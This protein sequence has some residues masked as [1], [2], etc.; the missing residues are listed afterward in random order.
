MI[1]LCGIVSEGPLARVREQLEQLNAPYLVFNQRQFATMAMEFEITQGRV[2]GWL[3]VEVHR[4]PLE[5]FIG[6]YNRLMDD[7]RLPE[8]EGE[9]ADSIRR[10]QCRA[11][12]D[13][14]IRW[15]ELSPARVVNRT[16]P[17]G[18][19]F[20]K[21]Y[22]IQLIQGHEF[23]VPETLITN[24]PEQVRA[25]RRRHRSV[26]YKSISGVRSVVRMLEP[27]DDQR[28]EHIRWCP[29]QFQAFVEG[30]NVRVHTVGTAVLQRLSKPR[31]P[32]TAMQSSKGA[33]RNYRLSNSLPHSRN[34]ASNSRGRW[35]WPSP[36]RPEDYP[37][38]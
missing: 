38:E 6:V 9:P 21:P 2:S 4:Y 13:T 37:A 36:H 1:L 7:R 25:F 15:C 35:G 28:L 31:Q 20:S 32:I 24:D 34:G 18:S 10:R 5:N 11:P 27:E 19:N 3:Q 17:M 12:H 16:V 23:A 29:T 14:L 22:Q 8:L 26:I 33:R 30:T